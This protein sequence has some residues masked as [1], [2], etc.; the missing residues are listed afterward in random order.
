[1][2][3]FSLWLGDEELRAAQGQAQL[4]EAEKADLL[5]VYIQTMASLEA[6]LETQVAV[7]RASRR[8]L[9]QQCEGEGRFQTSRER[10]TTT[11]KAQR[12]PMRSREPP[13]FAQDYLC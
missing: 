6:L 2:W 9:R 4:A 12:F 8:V 5:A 10:A 3:L 11:V 1:M 7:R 13:S